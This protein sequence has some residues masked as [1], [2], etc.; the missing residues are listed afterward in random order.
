M[1]GESWALLYL[2]ESVTNM[3]NDDWYQASCTEDNDEEQPDLC[4][5]QTKRKAVTS[6]SDD[7]KDD[8]SH[9]RYALGFKA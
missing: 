7:R 3:H 5:M 1:K 8:S 9:Y 6:F 4:P 2:L